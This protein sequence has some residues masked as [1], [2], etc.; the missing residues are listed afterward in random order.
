M[1]QK[2]HK[3]G[4]EG[5]KR[6]SDGDVAD[7]SSQPNNPQGP[8][9]AA[10]SQE[11]NGLEHVKKKVKQKVASADYSRVL[12]RLYNTGDQKDC[13]TVINTA[14]NRFGIDIDPTTTDLSKIFT[15]ETVNLEKVASTV[16]TTTSTVDQQNHGQQITH[17]LTQIKRFETISVQAN[18]Q[19]RSLVTSK[20]PAAVASA[21]VEPAKAAPL[22]SNLSDV[23]KE[24]DLV[25]SDMDLESTKVHSSSHHSVL[26]SRT[27]FEIPSNISM[28][29][30][31]NVNKTMDS[32]EFSGHSMSPMPG[33]EAGKIAK[34]CSTRIFQRVTEQGKIF[35]FMKSFAKLR[36]C[37][38][39]PSGF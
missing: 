29:Q 19:P 21:P 23:D 13:E 36:V 4:P 8:I 24:N 35:R 5:V 27:P 17:F 31:V 32:G 20:T 7:S 11:D 15:T 28:I 16:V 9:E 14:V 18:Q 26:S 37:F 22:S 33:S 30:G 34:F 6:K 25:S 1:N 3:Y 38:L 2:L 39:R 10:S 12:S